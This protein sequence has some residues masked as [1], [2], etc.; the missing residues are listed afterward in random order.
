[1]ASR[2]VSGKWIINQQGMHFAIHVSLAQSNATLTGEARYSTVRD[3]TDWL[4]IAGTRVRSSV[5]DRAKRHG[6]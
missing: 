6:R 2:D 4:V 1:M 5:L 3:T